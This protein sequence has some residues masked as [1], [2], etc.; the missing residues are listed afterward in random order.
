MTII[1]PPELPELAL[2]F[3]P[4]AIYRGGGPPP[5][6]PPPGAPPAGL[7]G[8]V[9][10]GGPVAFPM[11]AKR[12][13]DMSTY[14]TAD[15]PHHH[16]YEVHLSLS[17]RDGGQP[18]PLH[19]VT[20]DVELSGTI[21]AQQPIAWSMAPSRIDDADDRAVKFELQPQIKIAG[22]EA[23]A[24]TVT[25][26]VNRAREPFLLAL[27]ELSSNPVWELRRTGPP[28]AGRQ[29]FVLVVR[30]AKGVD[31]DVDIEVTATTKTTVLR[32]FQALPAPLKLQA[33]L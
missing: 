3:A 6:A 31:T 7:A 4:V 12:Y 33:R 23:S 2:D 32:R 22:V 10:L 19:T 13:P 18:P 24:G 17:F 15:A 20:L 14:I 25:G 30:A 5:G 16:Y 28:L 8:R 11:T 9:M 29:R 27:G 21:G 26:T 1:T